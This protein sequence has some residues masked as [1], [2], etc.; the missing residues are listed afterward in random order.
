VL[1]SSRTDVTQSTD[2]IPGGG[3]AVALHEP[4]A[5]PRSPLAIAHRAGNHLALL[6][7]AE[8]S[9]ADLV[10]ADLWLHR[11]RVEVRHLRTFGE[12]PV[13]V[14]WDRWQLARGWGERLTLPE[15]LAA[16]S[17]GTR[18]LLDLKG[19]DVRLASQVRRTMAA[20]AP[21]RP[22]AVCSQSW[23]LL[24]AFR[25]NELALIVHSVGDERMLR[26]IQER[27]TWHEH[28][29]VG[30]DH[31]LLTA[32]RVTALRDLVPAVFA[33]TVNSESR[34]HELVDWG[35]NGIISDRL[36]VLESLLATRAA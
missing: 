33:W 29:A 17:P 1:V 11:G 4:W 18:F 3:I 27:L 16:A 22:Y 23:E 5:P 28:Q 36:E 9:G 35:V 26:D 30:V 14:L 10:E 6:Q 21:D 25:G 34:M 13:P 2:E 15:L 31:R 32:P 24:E 20:L 12:L 7:T 19:I 8:R